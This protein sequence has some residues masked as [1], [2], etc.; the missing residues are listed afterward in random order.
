MANYICDFVRLRA[1]NALLYKWSIYFKIHNGHYLNFVYTLE[2]NKES[3]LK[4]IK[5]AIK[6]KEFLKDFNAMFFAKEVENDVIRQYMPVVF[7]VMRRFNVK[8]DAAWETI[9]DVAV[10]ALRGSVWRYRLD[11]TKFLSYAMT[12][13]VCAVRGA[14]FHQKEI[15]NRIGPRFI[16]I[17]RSETNDSVFAEGTTLA[18]KKT[19]EPWELIEEGA[20]ITEDNV[21]K[22]S[23]LTADEAYL[24][25][26]RLEGTSY[27]EK[28]IKYHTK[29]YG[30]PCNKNTLYR[31]WNC[32]KKKIRLK[33]EEL[34]GKKFLQKL[35]V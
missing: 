20:P 15:A 5:N 17:S 9:F 21:A 12:G 18:C 14:V 6:K 31:V 25:E 23:G 2:Q 10:S 16:H 33:V 13:V 19:P 1:S 22:L 26:L 7:N 29:K 34:R 28:F 3:L 4:Q 30:K 8:N 24:L 11:T 32:A 35:G 27:R